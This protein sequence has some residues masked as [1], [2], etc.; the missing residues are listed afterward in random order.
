M[1]FIFY[2]QLRYCNQ[3]RD[4]EGNHSHGDVSCSD[5]HVHGRSV[6]D[7]HGDEVHDGSRNDGLVHSEGVHARVRVRAHKDDGRND[8]RDHS[9][10]DCFRSCV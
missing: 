10:R 5:L 1:E 8:D 4:D 9:D 3:T 7:G 6:H 2:V